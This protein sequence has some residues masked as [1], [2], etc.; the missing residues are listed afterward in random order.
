MDI[1]TYSINPKHT[2]AEIGAGTESAWH[3]LP[4]EHCH[5]ELQALDDRY[6]L[7]IGRMGN[8]GTSLGIFDTVERR[9]TNLETNDRLFAYTRGAQSSW[10][11]APAHR[12]LFM[13]ESARSREYGRTNPFQYLRQ[14]SVDGSINRRFQ[15]APDFSSSTLVAR[16]DGRIV[17][18]GVDK[19]AVVDPAG[20]DTRLSTTDVIHYRFGADQCLRWFSPDG[21]W[22]LRTHPALIVRPATPLEE[23]GHPDLASDGTRQVGR[24]LDL[25]RLDPIGFERTLIIRYDEVDDEAFA[26]LEGLCDQRDPEVWHDRWGPILS[27]TGPGQGWPGWLYEW[28]EGI[29]WDDDGAG[30]TVAW[31]H[32]TREV[33]SPFWGGRR[34]ERVTDLA[35]RHVS[36][37]GVAGPATVI[38]GD[39][40]VRTELPSKTAIES[41]RALVRERSRQVVDCGGWTGTGVAAALRETRRRIEEDGLDALVFGSQ[42]QLNFRVGGRTIG[43][44]KF[45]ETVRKMANDDVAKILPELRELL[46]SYGSAAREF[47]DVYIDPIVSGP[48]EDSPAALSEA[49]LTLAMLDE[50]GFDALRDWVVAVDQE[51]DLFAAAKVFPAMARRTGFA[52]AEAV[53][54]GLWFFLQQWQTVRYEKTYLGL[55]KAAAAVMAPAAFASIVLAEARE[56]ASFSDATDT[57]TGVRS[58]KDML[59]RT[60]WDRAVSAELDRL[61]AT[62]DDPSPG[63]RSS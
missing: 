32:Q 22:G 20:G 35:E 54:F 7:A 43:E 56:V 37:D 48:A 57:E 3:F 63:E 17:C 15:I 47:Q 38:F 61:L 60:V 30:F 14:L 58:V 53:R 27:R 6:V 55:F 21:R 34:T 29:R 2:V 16:D 25:F 40:K 10:C 11:Y 50:V 23:E 36:L 5:A 33:P 62:L 26:I 31:T 52:T 4:F 45:F 51:H 42:L 59:G 39:L 41:I 49:A 19:V 13:V 9:R 46:R 1:R 8:R 24:A 18:V 28:I 44:K 12:S